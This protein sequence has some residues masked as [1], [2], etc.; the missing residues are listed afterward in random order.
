MWEKLVY[1]DIYLATLVPEYDIHPPPH[2]DSFQV[3]VRCR[4]GHRNKIF[5]IKK[6][7]EVTSELFFRVNF[8]VHLSQDEAIL[9]FSLLLRKFV[10][11]W[12]H[13]TLV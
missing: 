13:T 8:Y 3:N 5:L 10:I 2:L 7:H 1:I 11:L 12:T 4:N 6:W 9:R